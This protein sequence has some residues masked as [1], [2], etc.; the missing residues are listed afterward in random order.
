M[1]KSII[2]FF[3]ALLA[4]LSATAAV[5]QHQQRDLSG[6]MIR[7]HV[8]ANS[9]SEE[10]QAL[11]LCVRDAVLEVT[12]DVKDKQALPQYLPNIRQA[13]Q[14]CLRANGSSDQV[15]VTLQ[16]EHFPTRI[17]DNFALPAGVYTALRVTIG[18]GEG[19]N[20]WC[21]AFPSICFRV[22]ASDLEQAAQA[23][24]FTQSEIGLIT[25]E[26][27]GYEL[28]FKALEWLD[29]LKRKLF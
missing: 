25:E 19:H 10:D 22:T 28:K 24:G 15:V 9:D 26:G 12:K 4:A 6:K 18:E 14:Q 16:K 20:W 1:K 11:K 27:S 29:Q 23:G 8:V 17:Y 3:A 2:L 13:A 21:V 5:L 7:L